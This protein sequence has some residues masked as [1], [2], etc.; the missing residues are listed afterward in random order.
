MIYKLGFAGYREIASL[1]V[2][3][4]RA[5]CMCRAGSVP[6]ISAKYTGTRRS[7]AGDQYGEGDK[8]QRMN[9]HQRHAKDFIP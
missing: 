7:V 8:G 2:G 3:R 6:G 4:G 9:G 1:G 5:N